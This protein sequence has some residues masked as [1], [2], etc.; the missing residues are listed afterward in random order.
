MFTL[1]S[2][3][4]APGTSLTLKLLGVAA[5]QSKK[6][7]HIEFQKLFTIICISLVSFIWNYLLCLSNTQ[8]HFLQ[9]QRHIELLVNE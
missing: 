2:L 5:A 9:L 1:F 4:S 8:K 6:S 3:I 7:F